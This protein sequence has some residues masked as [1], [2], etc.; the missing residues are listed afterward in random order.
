MGRKRIIRRLY[1]CL[2]VESLVR[3]ACESRCRCC[4]HTGYWLGAKKMTPS[5]GVVAN[6][7]TQFSSPRIRAPVVIGDSRIPVRLD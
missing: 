3:P 5:T 6:W 4:I 2:P 7:W 1:R